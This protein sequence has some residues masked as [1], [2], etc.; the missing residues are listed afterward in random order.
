[1]SIDKTLKFQGSIGEYQVVLTA[2]G[3]PTLHS[4]AFNESCHSTHGA[5][6][7]TRYI[8][9][10]GC[11]I[12][13]RNAACIFE[14]GFGL[15]TGWQES[16]QA[17][18]DFIFYST[19]LDEK[20]VYWSQEQFNLFDSLTKEDN[21]L[22]GTKKNSKAI[23]LLGDAR[24]TVKNFDFEKEFDA[25]YQDAFSPKRNPT[26]WTEEWFKT[27]LNLSSE[28]VILS[29]YSASSRIKKSLFCAGWI[30]EERQ[31]FMGKRSSTRGFRKGEMSDQLLTKLSNPKIQPMSD[32]EL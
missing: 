24:D 21:V 13:K 10:E 4:E 15:G 30:L 29:T 16:I 12:V 20:L 23:I 25:I 31:G 11:E 2:D 26:L 32:L 6:S 17:H 3:S 8:Y 18:D 1:M 5:A 27:L 22:I 19:E 28:S 7:E 9:V 14:V